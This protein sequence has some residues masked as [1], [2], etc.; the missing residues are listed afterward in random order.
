MKKH[1]KVEAILKVPI[2][3]EFDSKNYNNSN[4][5]NKVLEKLKTEIAFMLPDFEYLDDDIDNINIE[6][7]DI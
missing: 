1:I 4:F 5:K 3:I 2:T 6:I 7:T